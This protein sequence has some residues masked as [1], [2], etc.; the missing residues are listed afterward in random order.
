[1]S[2]GSVPSMRGITVLAG[3]KPK[4]HQVASPKLTMNHQAKAATI[5]VL[6]GNEFCFSYN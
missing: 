3:K 6:S 2:A 5:A 1:M 4:E